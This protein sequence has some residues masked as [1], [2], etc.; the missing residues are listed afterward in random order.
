MTIKQKTKIKIWLN[1]LKHDTHDFMDFIP[2]IKKLINTKSFNKKDKKNINRWFKGYSFGYIKEE[3][4]ILLI[5][6]II[7]DGKQ[8]QK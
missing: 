1:N 7:W 2:L 3:E 4:V 6:R 8:I 5:K